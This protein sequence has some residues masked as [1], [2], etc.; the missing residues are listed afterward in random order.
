SW[1]NDA[2]APTEAVSAADVRFSREDD[3]IQVDAAEASLA[4]GRTTVA[5]KNGHVQL[6]KRAEGYRVGEIGA[7]GLEAQFAL[8]GK[9]K[10]AAPAVASPTTEAVEAPRGAGALRA[11]L[12]GAARSLDNALEPGA[13]VRFGGVHARVQSGDD[14]VNLGPGQL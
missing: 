11:M 7:D 4:V 8:P 10:G 2:S 14:S 1:K 3:R 6:V 9:K 5:V 12:M 13:K